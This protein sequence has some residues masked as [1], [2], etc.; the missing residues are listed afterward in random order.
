[1]TAK[2]MQK[3]LANKNDG[4]S[5]HCAAVMHKQGL[6]VMVTLTRT[7]SQRSTWEVC[8]TTLGEVSNFG[9]NW[10]SEQIK[11]NLSSKGVL[12]F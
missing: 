7:S 8:E 2:K 11:L 6:P 9:N 3:G 4:A 12:G 10:S 1:M 5:F